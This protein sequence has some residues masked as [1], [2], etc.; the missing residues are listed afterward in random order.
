[1][2]DF[3]ALQ[4]CLTIGGGPV[5]AGCECFDSEPTDGA[6]DAT[7]FERFVLCTSGDGV[8]WVPTS[9]CP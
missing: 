9:G 8:A 6:V 4:R 5:V 7:D 1:M 3:A 2:Q